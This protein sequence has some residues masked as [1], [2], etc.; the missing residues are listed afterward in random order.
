MTNKEILAE[1]K[2]SYEYLRDIR[3]NGCIDHCAGQMKDNIDK[4]EVAISNLEDIYYDFYKTL[5]KEDL[6][7]KSLEHKVDRDKVYICRCVDGD[8]EVGK[9]LSCMTCCDL[10]Y[11]WYEDEDFIEEIGRAH[12]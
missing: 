4:L 2:K 6:R 8:Y 7:V 5:D 10:E 9:D 3:E 1:L 11:Y 12:V